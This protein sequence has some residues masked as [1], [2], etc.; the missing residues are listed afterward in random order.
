M[1]HVL[2]RV[3]EVYERDSQRC[4]AFSTQEQAENQ[5]VF[6]E[7]DLPQANSVVCGEAGML[8]ALKRTFQENDELMRLL[9]DS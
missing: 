3:W 4:I 2:K 9:S 8:R 1:R 6:S 7:V 5:T